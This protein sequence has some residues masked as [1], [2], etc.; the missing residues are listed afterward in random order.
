MNFKK[1]K[2]YKPK[3]PYLLAPNQLLVKVADSSNKNLLQ[4]NP[5]TTLVGKIK[6]NGLL[7][8][9]YIYPDALCLEEPFFKLNPLMAQWCIGMIGSNK[10]TFKVCYDFPIEG[11]E[12]YH[13]V[14]INKFSSLDMLGPDPIEVPKDACSLLKDYGANRSR[15]IENS[16]DIIKMFN[17]VNYQWG[18]VFNDGNVEKKYIQDMA[19][20]LASLL[21]QFKDN[22]RLAPI[23]ENLFEIL[24]VCYIGN[25]FQLK[26][27]G[28]KISA[29]VKQ[30]VHDT[31]KVLN[32]LCWRL[33]NEDQWCELL[34]ESRLQMRQKCLEYD[35]NTEIDQ[36]LKAYGNNLK[37][38][39]D[40]INEIKLQINKTCGWPLFDD[41]KGKN[42]RLTD[43]VLVQ[44]LVKSNLSYMQYF[45]FIILE[46]QLDYLIV[47]K[48]RLEHPEFKIVESWSVEKI[49]IIV[50]DLLDQ[51]ISFNTTSCG[52]VALVYLYLKEMSKELKY[53][54][55]LDGCAKAKLPNREDGKTLIILE[56]TLAKYCMQYRTLMFD[57]MLELTN[58]P[59]STSKEA[60]LL[61]S[62]N[63]ALKHLYNPL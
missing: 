11:K 52:K 1:K 35:C 51:K 24:P 7:Q 58:D 43:K 6:A 41:T 21:T 42:E 22:F 28:T 61:R 19:N 53:K 25:I 34:N 55:F 57:Y 60:T 2:T 36:K 26:L 29:V 32:E 3:R 33:L 44:R 49:R 13:F 63:G 45:K 48:Y 50:Q 31:M 20:E 10:T 54:T 12:G 23:Q 39:N 15:S 47:Q 9:V 18:T 30:S 38:V 5:N 4:L 37:A 46:Y 17:T 16:H 27:K 8:E 62:I 40:Y 59:F 14:S 56:D